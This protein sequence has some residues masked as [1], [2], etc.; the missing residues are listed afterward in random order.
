MEPVYRPI[1]GGGSP[2]GGGRGTAEAPRSVITMEWK[3]DFL[4][5]LQKNQG[6]KYH[7]TQR[8]YHAKNPGYVSYLP[9]PGTH[10]HSF[11]R[12]VF[13]VIRSQVLLSATRI[14][15]IMPKLAFKE[16]IT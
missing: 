13:P 3:I 7:V 14:P 16:Q 6:S 9:V 11:Q 8:N 4:R 15:H 1:A 5:L 2:H 10:L 12:H